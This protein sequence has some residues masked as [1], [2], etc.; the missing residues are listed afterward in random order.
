M[1]DAHPTTANWKVI[2]PYPKRMK[3][4]T[5]PQEVEFYNK[6]SG[7]WWDSQG[8]IWPLHRLNPLRTLYIKA[9]LIREFNL[10]PE[11]DKPLQGLR[12]LD[13]GCGG[14]I[15]S[16]EMAKLGASVHG[17][18]VA[19]K[20]IR[21][22][23]LHAGQSGLSIVYET[24]SAEILAGRGE[25]YDVI[26]NMEVV[27]HVAELKLFMDACIKLVKPNGV[28][29][30]ATLNRTFPAFVSAILFAEYL[31]G[32][33]PKGTHRWKRFRKPLELENILEPQGMKLIAQTG[34]S[35]NPFNLRFYF[36]KYMGVN[37]MLAAK[38]NKP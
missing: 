8:P 21:V 32:W 14:G 37:Y 30:I 10:N 34:V 12:I 17:V 18:D 23:R 2:Q 33:L 36:C 31:L 24:S 19:D 3:T 9:V 25:L 20:N 22:A 29:F 5:D 15:L 1:R 27:E 7:L 11:S 6:L 35:I 13:I 4:S 16:E 28:M 26:L 38:K